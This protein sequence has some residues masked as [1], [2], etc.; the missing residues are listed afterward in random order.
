MAITY[1][2]VVVLWFLKK[3]VRYAIELATAR[4]PIMVIRLA[5]VDAT[6]GG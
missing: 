4:Y 1:L 6:K 3:R 5:M 2:K